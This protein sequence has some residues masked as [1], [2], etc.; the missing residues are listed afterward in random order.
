VSTKGYAA[1]D[2]KKKKKKG[3]INKLKRTGE[4]TE[5]TGG[6]TVLISY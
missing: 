1:G 2:S 4:G 3:G 5:K 6:K